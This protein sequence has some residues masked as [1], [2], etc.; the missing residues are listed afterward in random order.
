MT[1]K[2]ENDISYLVRKA[3]YNIHVALGPGLLESVYETL[4]SHELRKMGLLVQTQV[5]LPVV[6]DGLKLDNGF[7]IDLLVEEKVVV[8]LKSVEILLEVHHMQLLTYLKLS[9]HKLGLLINFNVPYI[10]NGIFRKV[11]GL[12]EHSASSAP[13]SAPSAG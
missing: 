9:G 5:P 8:E 2:H 4:L 11:N 3:A 1:Q 10:K 12:E 6:Y 13:T 7:R